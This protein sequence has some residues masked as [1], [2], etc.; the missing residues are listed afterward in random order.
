MKVLKSLEEIESAGPGDIVAFYGVECSSG[1]TFTDGDMNV[2]LTSMHVPAAVISLAVKPKERT[3]EQNFSKALNRFTKEDRDFIIDGM[4][5]L[6]IG[7]ADFDH[8]WSARGRR[9]GILS[10][11]AEAGR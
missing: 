9:H 11:G 2:T 10:F 4:H 5:R 3:G 7:A 6:D 1:E 8:L